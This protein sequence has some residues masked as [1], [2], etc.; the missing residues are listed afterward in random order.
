M[1]SR[2]CGSGGQWFC[3]LFPK[4]DRGVTK[5]ASQIKMSW[6]IMVGYMYRLCGDRRQTL[7]L[8][9]PDASNLTVH[10]IAEDRRGPNRT[11]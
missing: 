7:R 2:I 3:Y 9:V 4:I 6:Q 10:T 1:A 11:K 8:E 5:P